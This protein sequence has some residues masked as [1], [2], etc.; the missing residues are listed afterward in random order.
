MSVTASLLK[1]TG[2]SDTLH[3]TSSS[4]LIDSTSSVKTINDKTILTQ[5][6][7]QEE[8]APLEPPSVQCTLLIII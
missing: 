3:R 2:G 7:L 5:G 4:V 6:L 1:T 8:G